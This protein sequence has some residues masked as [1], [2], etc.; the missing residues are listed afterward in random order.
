M[1]YYLAT[2]TY[3]TREGRSVTGSREFSYPTCLTELSDQIAEAEYVIGL[4]VSRRD[5]VITSV[6]PAGF[7]LRTEEV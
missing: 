6:R 4:V 2:F 5:L 7:R 1:I 3:T